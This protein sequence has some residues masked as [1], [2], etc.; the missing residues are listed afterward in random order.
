MRP[1][2]AHSEYYMYIHV[3]IQPFTYSECDEDEF[4]CPNDL[5]RRC[6]PLTYLCDDFIDCDDGFDEQNCPE[7]ENECIHAFSLN[8]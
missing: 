7:S 2:Y 1:V 5:S 4:Q 3:S 8:G 6:F